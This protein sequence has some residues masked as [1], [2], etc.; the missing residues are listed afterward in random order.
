M[1]LNKLLSDEQ[2]DVWECDCG[3]Y[4]PVKKGSPQPICELCRRRESKCH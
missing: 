3:T 4:T 1:K 2:I